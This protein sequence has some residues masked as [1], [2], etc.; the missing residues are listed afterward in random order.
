MRIPMYVRMTQKQ[1]EAKEAIIQIEK[2]MK[3]ENDPQKLYKLFC[4]ASNI[5]NENFGYIE[6]MVNFDFVPDHEK[7]YREA[8]KRINKTATA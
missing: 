6:A 2:R 3:W 5:W 1:Y 4:T 8:L 7:A